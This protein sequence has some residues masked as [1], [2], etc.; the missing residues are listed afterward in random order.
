M[1][2]V[3]HPDYISLTQEEKDSLNKTGWLIKSTQSTWYVISPAK[4][5]IRLSSEEVA[6]NYAY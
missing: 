6:W 5:I 4:Q 3:S 2:T 1:K